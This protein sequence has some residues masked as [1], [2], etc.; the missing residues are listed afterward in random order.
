MVVFVF[1]TL[2]FGKPQNLETTMGWKSWKKN[3]VKRLRRTLTGGK[4]AEL[5]PAHEE[6]NKKAIKPPA[7]KNVDVAKAAY[8]RDDLGWSLAK[9]G[10]KMH[11]DRG[12][13]R[14]RLR[15]WDATEKIR[16]AADAE[17]KRLRDFD[18][19]RERERQR[20][21]QAE[22]EEQARPQR[23][24]AAA[25]AKVAAEAKRLADIEAARPKPVPFV[26]PVTNAADLTEPDFGKFFLVN[27][28]PN[29]LTGDTNL[30][31]ATKH[32]Q[33][34]VAI[35][36]WDVRYR[37]LP[38]FINAVEIW[39][40]LDPS[41]NNLELLTSIAAD[42]WIADR[43]K[44]LG[45]QTHLLNRNGGSGLMQ[46]FYTTLSRLAS[47]YRERLPAPTEKTDSEWTASYGFVPVPLVTEPWKIDELTKMEP[48]QEELNHLEDDGWRGGG[49]T[50]GAGGAAGVERINPAFGTRAA[51]SGYDSEPQRDTG[52]ETRAP[53]SY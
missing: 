2:K 38:L 16:L 39:I 3:L 20:K 28:A 19:A 1:A 5:T 6:I 25:A 53:G 48:S 8:M 9:I 33:P 51:R 29:A 12:T 49:G 15:D 22:A 41:Q 40:P 24:A 18:A 47:Y 14:T 4:P 34:A 52:G 43:C 7:W 21:V 42:R 26:E 32:E 44:V 17:A 23:E 35:E 27:G 31:Y 10:R 30:P 45:S 50:G 37:E 13:I 11:L 46:V 36:K